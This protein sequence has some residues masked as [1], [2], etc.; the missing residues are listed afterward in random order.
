MG[1]VVWFSKT[2]EEVYLRLEET[3]KRRGYQEGEGEELINTG[4]QRPEIVVLLSYVAQPNL[5]TNIINVE[6]LIH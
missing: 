2:P 1:L 3:E 4:N 6:H 5:M